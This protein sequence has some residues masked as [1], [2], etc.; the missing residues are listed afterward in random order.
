MR[1]GSIFYKLFQQSPTL[2]FE[3]LTNPVLSL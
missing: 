2:L 3:L 1:R